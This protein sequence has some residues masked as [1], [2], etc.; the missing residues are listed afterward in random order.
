[1]HNSEMT[2][3]AARPSVGKTA[4]GI[5]IA[6]QMAKKGMVVQCFSRE[7]SQVQLG[8]RLIA[9]QGM[10]DGQRMRTGNIRDDDWSKITK[11]MNELYKVPMFI[12]DEASTIPAIRA[13]CSEKETQRPRHDI[14]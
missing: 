1:M 13:V 3:L 8:T 11:S 14:D 10:V 4:L 9:N 6:L 7:M 2:I 5:Q 12:N